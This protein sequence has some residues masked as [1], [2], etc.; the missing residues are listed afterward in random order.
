MITT[1]DLNFPYLS[2]LR[3]LGSHGMIIIGLKPF[4]EYEWVC[5]NEISKYR[6]IRIDSLITLIFFVGLILIFL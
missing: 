4:E 6:N 5:K 1:H 2:D 3:G